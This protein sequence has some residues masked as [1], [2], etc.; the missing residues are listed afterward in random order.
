MSAHHH[1][2]HHEDVKNIKTAF[3]LNLL[4]TVIEFAGG[5]LTNSMAIL[6]DAVHD[7]GDSFSLGLSWYF[8][9]VAKRPRSRNFTYGYKRFS[10]LGAIVNS[11]ILLVGSVLI[12]LNS[13][14]RLLRPEQPDTQGML[15]LA[16]LGV[17]VNGA[18]VFRLRKGRSL[19]EKAVSL[20]MLEDVLGWLSVLIGAL[21]MHFVD[22]P[23]IDPL[24]SIAIAVFILV[25][26]FRNARQSFCII[27]Q[28]KPSEVNLDEV[29][30]SIAALSEVGSV[31]DLHVWSV[32]GEYN[33]LTI[34]VV[35]N[36]ELT[37]GE[38]QNL[39]VEIRQKLHAL[40]IQHAT[41]EFEL[42]NEQ[43]INNCDE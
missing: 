10:L 11:V 32:D 33:V 1:H 3:F 13:I 29:E 38:L 19:N 28:G 15:L 36:E 9:K 7:L 8:Q 17:I 39:K 35:L 16:V 27:L 12:L 6:S 23:V 30:K 26:V 14:P 2:H 20:H 21:V 18:A 41:I 22:A 40:N 25:N 4:F 5:I 37:N 31:H 43:C 24:L 42:S 34:H